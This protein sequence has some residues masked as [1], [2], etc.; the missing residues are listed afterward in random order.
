LKIEKLIRPLQKTDEEGKDLKIIISTPQNYNNNN[1]LLRQSKQNHLKI[2][3]LPRQ[4]GKY[5]MVK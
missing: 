2:M 3:T 1:E 5:S 4:I